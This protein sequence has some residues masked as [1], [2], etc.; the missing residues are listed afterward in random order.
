MWGTGNSHVTGISH[1]ENMWNTG[2]PHVVTCEVLVTHM[3]HVSYQYLTCHNMGDTCISHVAI[4]WDTCRPHVKKVPHMSTVHLTC[5]SCK[6]YQETPAVVRIPIMIK[7]RRKKTH[8]RIINY[9]ALNYLC[10][11]VCVCLCVSAGGCMKIVLR[12]ARYNFFLL[13]DIK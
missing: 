12:L 3:L 4:M 13:W 1:D 9:F 5:R 2:I 8:N 10:Y 11:C 7:P 6:R